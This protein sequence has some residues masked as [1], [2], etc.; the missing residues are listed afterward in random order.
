MKI[1]AIVAA[2]LAAGCAATPPGSPSAGAIRG[3]IEGV[4]RFDSEAVVQVYRFDDAGLPTPDPFE[5]IAPDP[6]GRFS[7]R[8]LSPGRYRI[9]YRHPDGPPSEVSVRVAGDTEAVLRP[10]Y[11]E[12]LVQLRVLGPRGTAVRCRLTEADPNGGIP[13]VRDFTT[14]A[15]APVFLRGIRPGRWYLD[16]PEAGATTEVDVP[17]GASLQDLA[18]DPPPSQS[19]SVVCGEVRRVDALP[20]AWLVVTARPVPAPGSSAARWGRYATTDRSGGY[21]IV[22]IP[23][24]TA[25]VRVECREVAVRVLP[26]AQTTSIPP[27]GEVQLGFVVEP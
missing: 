18:V 16:L 7:T 21:R 5:T 23:P 22:G 10:L 11:V 9:V 6:N 26:A 25:L 3:R 2:L 1:A 19:G 27:S 24:G 17:S 20:G 13:D 15:D 4:Q 12:G 8:V 14:R